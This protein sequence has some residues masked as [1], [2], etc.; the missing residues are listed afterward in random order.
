MSLTDLLGADG[1]SGLGYDE[2]SWWGVVEQVAETLDIGSGT[3]VWDVECGAGSFLF[4][5]H[6]NGYFVGGAC[7]SAEHLHRARLA[8]P[9]GQFLAGT[10]VSVAPPGRWDVVVASRGLAARDLDEVRRLLSHMVRHATHA[11]AVLDAD[12][13]TAPHADRAG[14]MRVLAEAGVSAVQF[15]AGASSRWHLFARIGGS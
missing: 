9:D 11:V 14:M 5:L 7:S 13:T 3:R 15:E 2:D 6:R 4:P 1:R 10:G 8:M 12:E